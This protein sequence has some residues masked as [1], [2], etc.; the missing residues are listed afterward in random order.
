[1]DSIEQTL[2]LL[3]KSGGELIKAVAKSLVLKIKPYDF[4]EFKHSAIY[5]A[6]R[7]YNEKR[8][9]VIRLSGLYSPL[10][11]LEKEALKEEPFSLIVNVDEQTFKQGFIWYSP[12]KD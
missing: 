11:G 1:M 8:D 10:F 4:V 6:I 7:T 3:S 5:R 2:L 9:S 12:E